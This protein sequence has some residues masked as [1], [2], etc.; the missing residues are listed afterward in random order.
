MAY[1]TGEMD[2]REEDGEPMNSWGYSDKVRACA[3]N[4][5]TH[6]HSHEALFCRPRLFQS[7]H[8]SPIWALATSTDDSLPA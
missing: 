5:H 7:L 8:T 2:H 4:T 6:T 1:A 3:C